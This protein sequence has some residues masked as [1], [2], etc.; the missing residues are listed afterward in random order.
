[1]I[2]PDGAQS[3]NEPA[4]NRVSDT[5]WTG[6]GIRLLAFVG[7]TVLLLGLSL[8]VTIPFLPAITWAVA[9]AIIAWPL[10]KGIARQLP[11]PGVAA[12]LST[13]II[14]AVIVLPGV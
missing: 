14:V 1:M 8:L 4:P 3:A 2:P 10:H 9:L 5:V 7:L 12:A 6:E 13:G 11:W